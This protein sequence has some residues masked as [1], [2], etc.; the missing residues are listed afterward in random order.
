MREGDSA[1]RRSSIPGAVLAAPSWCPFA[2][3]NRDQSS[4]PISHGRSDAP[5]RLRSSLCCRAPS[6]PLPMVHAPHP[7]IQAQKTQI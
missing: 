5:S 7:Y 2:V 3:A 6:H 4:S 1:L